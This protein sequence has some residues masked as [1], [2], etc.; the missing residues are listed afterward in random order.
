MTMAKRIGKVEDDNL[1][2]REAVILWMMEAHT[3]DSLLDYAR[4]LMDQPDES[5]PLIR[6]PAQVVAAVRSK[7]KGQRDELLR[8]E[9]YQVQRDLLFLYFLHNRLN[10]H[11]TR[12][13]ETICSRLTLLAEQLRSLVMRK[14]ENDRRRIQDLKFPEDLS[15]LESKKRGSSKKATTGDGT[16]HEALTAWAA[17]EREL[18]AQVLTL[19]EAGRLLARRYLGG[20]EML[21]SQSLRRCAASLEMLSGLRAVY[22]EA[23]LT[24]P[25]PADEDLIR[26]MIES[27]MARDSQEP[28]VLP[29]PS[30]DEEKDPEVDDEATRLARYLVTV[31]KAEA[32]KTLGDGDAGLRL[33]AEW[34]RANAG[35]AN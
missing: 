29:P 8:D 5:Y 30:E 11:V 33:V 16:L 31:A 3:F 1:T 23:T 27:W 24:G 25:P 4:W 32:L 35:G 10:F 21:H 26:W 22:R 18:R 7:N 19:Q 20:E 6:M 2:P 17:Q 28:T 9:F 14:A 13:E 34:L 15:K 12:E